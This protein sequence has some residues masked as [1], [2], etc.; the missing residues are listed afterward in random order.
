M[1]FFCCGHFQEGRTILFRLLCH[2]LQPQTSR[3]GFGTQ[4]SVQLISLKKLANCTSGTSGYLS[5]NK[6]IMNCKIVMVYEQQ[7]RRS[8][9]LN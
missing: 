1:I 8:Q 9:F 4:S 7:T 6:L 5:L 3:V 2:C